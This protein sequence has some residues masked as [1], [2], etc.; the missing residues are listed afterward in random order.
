MHLFQPLV[1]HLP[2]AA[3]HAPVASAELAELPQPEE[4]M[5][6]P[7]SMNADNIS[8]HS[9]LGSA[10]PTP[11]AAAA[12]GVDIICK[13]LANRRRPEF[14]FCLPYDSVDVP[15]NTV[16]RSMSACS[17]RCRRR[18]SIEQRHG[19]DCTARKP[20]TARF[21]ASKHVEVARTSHGRVL[22]ASGALPAARRRRTA[23]C[24]TL[25]EAIATAALHPA[26]MKRISCC[27]SCA[28][29]FVATTIWSLTGR[30]VVY[31][32]RK[33]PRQTH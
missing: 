11:G 33:L 30:D 23:A 4:A 7:V 9:I 12:Q 18:R 31:A 19:L 22:A 16:C 15:R 1:V 29:D 25:A 14:T 13:R 8:H 21:Q 10:A 28:E 27:A 3:R 26:A 6:A 24:G 20:K 32:C 2:E 5:L 17:T